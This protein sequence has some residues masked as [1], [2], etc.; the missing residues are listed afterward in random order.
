MTLNL[1]WSDDRAS[2][3]IAD[4]AR[5]HNGSPLHSHSLL[6]QLQKDA[7]KN[8]LTVEEGAQKII[9]LSD[10]CVATLCGNA[11]DA[12]EFAKC[13]MN[14]AASMD[15]ALLLTHL[16]SLPTSARFAVGV[17]E[18]GDEPFHTYAFPEK[19]VR[20]TRRREV[21]ING[22]LGERFSSLVTERILHLM[23]NSRE[24]DCRTAL[25]AG[26]AI[27]TSVAAANN[28]TQEGVGGALFGGYVTDGK[29]FW[30]PDISYAF[31]AQSSLEQQATATETSTTSDAIFST[32]HTGVRDNVSLAATAQRGIAAVSD[33]TIDPNE[34]VRKWRANLNSALGEPEF[35]AFVPVDS[36]GIT[37]LAR[38][39]GNHCRVTHGEFAYTSYLEAIMKKTHQEIGAGLVI[40]RG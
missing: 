15:V 26:L 5:S 23:D 32:V 11:F 33:L 7:G 10:S 17:T 8:G 9:P 4:S 13:L 12:T 25:A 3:V 31:Y 39:L 29:F 36:N 18:N 6:Q 14:T 1:L 30:Q 19:E 35:V 28:L 27:V 16:E 24:L 20:I 37:V 34:F 40:L 22:S 2:F 38:N 21:M